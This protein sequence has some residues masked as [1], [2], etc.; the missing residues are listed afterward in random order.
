MLQLFPEIGLEKHQFSTDPLKVQWQNPQKRRAFFEKFAQERQFDP[1]IPSNWYPVSLDTILE[2][3]NSQQVLRFHDG[4]FMNA[5]TEL[6]P[7]LY[8]DRHKFAGLPQKYWRNSDHRR[9]FFTKF[10]A[11]K[12]FDPFIPDNWKRIS[13]ELISSEPGGRSLSKHY[14][15]NIAKALVNVFPEWEAHPSDRHPV[16]YWKNIDHRR[17]FF[18]DIAETLGF[19]PL[20]AQNWYSVPHSS[21]FAH[22][23]STTMLRHYQGNFGNALMDVFPDIGLERSKLPSMVQWNEIS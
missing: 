14:K 8:W 21:I 23:Y 11:N 6:F 12:K 2:Q 7:E 16:N 13:N 19:D 18:K 10:A 4:S 20:I 22:K 1:L 15:G 17:N 9:E 3:K 5:V